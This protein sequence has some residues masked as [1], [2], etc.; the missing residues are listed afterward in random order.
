MVCCCF[1]AASSGGVTRMVG[2]RVEDMPAGIHHHKLLTQA[3]LP[4]PFSFILPIRW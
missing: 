1:P 2:D 3:G 4:P